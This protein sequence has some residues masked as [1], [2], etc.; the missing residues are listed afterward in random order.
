MC[1]VVKNNL[2]VIW[3]DTIRVTFTVIFLFTV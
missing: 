1:K 3:N 2:I